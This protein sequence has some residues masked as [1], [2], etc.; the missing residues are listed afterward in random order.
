MQN[1][2]TMRVHFKASAAS[3]AL[4]S[5]FVFHLALNR[6]PAEASNN[7]FRFGFRTR[8]TSLPGK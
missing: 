7:H 5:D 1:R 4:F 6:V 3:V 8:A 2:D